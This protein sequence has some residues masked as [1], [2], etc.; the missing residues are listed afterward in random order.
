MLCQSGDGQDYCLD[1]ELR[2]NGI[3]LQYLYRVRV[4]KAAVANGCADRVGRRR[5]DRRRQVPPSS[6]TAARR[7]HLARQEYRRLLPPGHIH[8]AQHPAVADLVRDQPIQEIDHA[9][10]SSLPEMAFEHFRGDLEMTPHPLLILTS[11]AR[12]GFVIG[13]W[14]R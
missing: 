6:G 10:C 11:V 13:R 14:K 9:P 8:L 3:S 5:S 1:T 2:L 4:G 7:P 12:S